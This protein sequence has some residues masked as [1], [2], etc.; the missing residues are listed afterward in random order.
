MKKDKVRK[1]ELR[2]PCGH[3]FIENT[4]QACFILRMPIEKQLAYFIQNHG[5]KHQQWDSTFRN[6]IQSGGCYKRLKEA[7]HIDEN[8][9]TVVWNTDGAQPFKSSK[10]GI[11]H[12]MATINNLSY[13]LRRS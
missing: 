3:L 10:N 5:I 2:Q 12:F 8:T 1:P 13:K 11:W 4:H 9:V 6:D 7:G